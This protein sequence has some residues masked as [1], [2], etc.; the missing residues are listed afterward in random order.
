MTV[1]DQKKIARNT[2]MLTIRFGVMTL[3][4]LYTVK[5][6]L[7]A[8]G[9]I[10]Y[11]IY[12]T[13]AAA[14]LTFS[15]LNS[16]MSTACQRFMAHG[17]VKNDKAEIRRVFSMCVL[18]FAAIALAIVFLC[19]TGGLWILH[20][21]IQLDNR[22]METAH[23]VFQL[24]ILSFI[25]TIMKTPYHGMII[26]REK[27]NV[28][29][30]LSIFEVFGSLGVALLISHSHSDRLILYS[31]LMLTVNAIVAISYFVYCSTV[32]KESRFKFYW[33][34]AEFKEILTFTSWNMFGELA[35][36]LKSYGLS[37]LINVFFANAMVTARTIG[38]KVYCMMLE[39]SGSVTTAIRPQIIKTYTDGD[40]EG[41]FKLLFQG[42]KFS[43]YLFLIV[44]LP[45]FLE[46]PFVLQIWLGDTPD[47]AQL[48][49]R[50]Y[51]I[52]GLLDS[53]VTP[54][55]ATMQAHGKIKVYQIVTSCFIILVVPVSWFL[56]RMGFPPETVLYVTIAI[57]AIAI[58]VRVAF[59][60]H[61]TGLIMWDYIRNVIYP[62]LLVT[63]CSAIIPSIVENLMD[64]NG[65]L[66]FISVTVISVIM[67]GITAYSLGMTV[68]ERK[69]TM[70]YI[71]KIVHKRV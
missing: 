51:I 64:G 65:I 40:R 46:T 12:N 26:M 19:E 70:N 5:V 27:M 23:I 47:Y 31:I 57:C 17:M 34:R 59:V 42:S 32:F 21:K 13:V 30:Y 29:T 14:V 8:L 50:L 61:Y 16:T 62:I 11:G 18:A 2:L 55:S 22:S 68:T 44:A 43:Y 52:V 25:F 67:T 20:Q 1:I 28:Y 33:N 41:T 54:L 10:D 36:N 37:V 48:F 4:K 63:V 45:M 6:V 9:E 58:F 35:M 53:I 39:F 60:S 24:A 71:A 49:S 3:V 7:A 56:L 38:Y 66:K 69:H 15:F